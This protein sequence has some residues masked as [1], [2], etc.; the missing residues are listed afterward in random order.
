MWNESQI[1][2]SPYLFVNARNFS[3]FWSNFYFY[4]IYVIIRFI[5]A[6]ISRT[7]LKIYD[8]DHHQADINL[9]IWLWLMIRNCLIRIPSN[10]KI[11]LIVREFTYD[12]DF[13]GNPIYMF[14][15]NNND[16]LFS[17]NRIL[18]KFVSSVSFLRNRHNFSFTR[19]SF[20]LAI[21]VFLDQIVITVKTVIDR[22]KFFIL[23]VRDH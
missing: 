17:R 6:V 18:G 13:R 9:I 22:S 3:F 10:T 4:E 23:F 12:V 2:L 5:H 1:M 16:R 14:C 8:L 15:V 11:R 20:F 21:L 19:I 7:T